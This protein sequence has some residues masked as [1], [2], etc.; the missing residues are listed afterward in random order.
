[1]FSR[2]ASWECCATRQR[3]IRVQESTFLRQLPRWGTLQR[4]LCR[5][6]GCLGNCRTRLN[7]IVVTVTANFSDGTTQNIELS[8]CTWTDTATQSDVL[9][10]QTTSVSCTYNGI[11]VKVCDVT[12]TRNPAIVQFENAVTNVTTA[13]GLQN[14]FTAIKQALDALND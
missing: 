1:M 14:K 4:C 12:V 3:G 10:L 2:G 7:S 6:M 11:T 5:S 8:S 9:T 13:Q